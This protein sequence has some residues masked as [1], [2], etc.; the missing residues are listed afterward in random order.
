MNWC[1]AMGTV[2]ANEEVINGLSERGGYPVIRKKM[3]QWSLRITAYADR[4]IEGLERIQWS[5][6]IKEIQKNWIGRSQGAE[7]DFVVRGT[8]KTLIVFR[9]AGINLYGVQFTVFPCGL[10]FFFDFCEGVLS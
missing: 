6:A 10:P 7:I 2:L 5:D 8:L 9:L 4:L 3:K 1:E